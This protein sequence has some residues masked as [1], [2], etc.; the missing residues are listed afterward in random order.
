MLPVHAAWRH[1][2]ADSR[3]SFGSFLARDIREASSPVEISSARRGSLGEARA[4]G[5]VQVRV[6]IVR[7]RRTASWGEEAGM[8]RGQTVGSLCT[9][10]DMRTDESYDSAGRDVRDGIGIAK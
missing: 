2:R 4:G 7:T 3:S 1:R 5:E 8:W 10:S 6:P 9:L